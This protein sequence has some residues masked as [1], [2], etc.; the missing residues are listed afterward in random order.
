MEYLKSC[1]VTGHR[2]FPKGQIDHIKAELKKQVDIAIRDGYQKF[3]SGFANGADI[4]FAEIICDKISSG[5]DIILE[6][7]IPHRARY[8]SLMRYEN[9]RKLLDA[10]S[11]I[12]VFSEVYTPDAYFERNRHMVDCSTRVI[13]V[14][15]GRTTGGTYMTYIHA[16]NTGKEVIIINP[17]PS[18]PPVGGVYGQLSLFDPQGGM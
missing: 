11:V 18:E 10:C 15:D 16:K 6:A 2:S 4:W 8:R 5:A 7:A 17:N 12:H 9:T 3:Y 14:Y 1:C 13:A